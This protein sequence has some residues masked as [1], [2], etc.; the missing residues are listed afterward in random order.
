MH[1]HWARL[2]ETLHSAEVLKNLLHDPTSR[3]R[4]SSKKAKKFPKASL[5]ERRA[6]HCPITASRKHQITMC[7]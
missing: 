4:S 1:T 2:I 5:I 6:A 7:N 3:G